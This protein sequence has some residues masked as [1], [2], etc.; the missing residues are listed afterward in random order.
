MITSWYGVGSALETFRRIRG[1]RGEAL[2]QC[3][4]RDNPLFHLIVDEVEK[5]LLLADMEIARKYAG[6]VEDPQAAKTIYDRIAKEHAL[7]CEMLRDITGQPLAERFP[8]LRARCE[9]NGPSLRAAHDLQVEL[10]RD[11]RRAP[12]SSG[13]ERI[14]LMQSMNCIAAGLGWTG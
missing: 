6:L 8:R 7:S 14:R 1:P 9:S 11:V 10:L 13:P 4:F 3:M 2:L 5:A 12:S